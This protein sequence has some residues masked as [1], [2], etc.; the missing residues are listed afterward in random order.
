MSSSRW[1]GS[2]LRAHNVSLPSS[3]PSDVSAVATS[4]YQAI[5]RERLCLYVVRSTRV[6]E[7]F[8]NEVRILYDFER[9]YRPDTSSE[10][11]RRTA[12]RMVRLRGPERVSSLRA[13]CVGASLRR[14]IPGYSKSRR[15]R[16]SPRN[17]RWWRN[18]WSTS[19]LLMLV[20]FC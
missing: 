18:R 6:V 10:N 4:T 7:A 5:C 17:I 16:I 12:Q 15:Q 9:K 1:K 3:R 8:K 14:T 13:I 20:G 11:A 2:P 19:G